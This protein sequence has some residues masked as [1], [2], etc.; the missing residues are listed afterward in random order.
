MAI[1]IIAIV[2]LL[3]A[4]GISIG[5]IR[6]RQTLKKEAQVNQ[7]E[8]WCWLCNKDTQQCTNLSQT[9]A[10][11]SCDD[12]CPNAPLCNDGIYPTIYNDI[13]P[14]C[15]S[16]KECTVIGGTWQM[17]RSIQGCGIN[18]AK[19]LLNGNGITDTNLCPEG[20]ERKCQNVRYNQY[21]E[22]CELWYCCAP[23]IK[24]PTPELTT[25]IT[26]TPITTLTPTPS[27]TVT[28]WPTPTLTLTPTLTATP[29]PSPTITDSPTPTTTLS[30][31]VTPSP[32]STL[33]PPPTPTS[34]GQPT[35]SP[36]I[37][38]VPTPTPAVC[39]PY[40]N[41]IRL[42]IEQLPPL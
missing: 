1:S 25:E 38:D 39:P 22:I 33:T 37:T 10:Q 20:Y 9:D 41:N 42:I 23:L 34:T 8:P 35:P 28:V 12:S 40:T 16:P 14:Q 3:A 7:F 36:S 27:T 4:I 29:T 31:T 32:T 15:Q 30:P 5:A 18:D 24:G 21:Q 17:Y 19:S 11:L 6:Q 2:V 26:S 13:S